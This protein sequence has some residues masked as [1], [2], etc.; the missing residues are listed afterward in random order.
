MNFYLIGLLF[1]FQLVDQSARGGGSARTAAYYFEFS[2]GAWV[3]S[4]SC[5]RASVQHVSVEWLHLNHVFIG[6]ICSSGTGK[7]DFIPHSDEQ[8]SPNEL[9][10]D[11]C[12]LST[13]D[14]A[15]WKDGCNQNEA[16]NS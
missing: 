7:K 10:V 4:A 8:C 2:P 3:P 14:A 5:H 9:S 11:M 16:I 1:C 15:N 6:W 12:V 13:Q